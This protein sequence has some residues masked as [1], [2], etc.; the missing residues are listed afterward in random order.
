M[1]S[2]KRERFKRLATLRTNAVLKRI[3][4]LAHC[5]NKQAY[6]YSEEEV[7]K[8]FQAIDGELRKARARF[9]SYIDENNDFKL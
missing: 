5:A 9:S 2:P 7:R 6:E 1:K 4:V 8:I 3:K